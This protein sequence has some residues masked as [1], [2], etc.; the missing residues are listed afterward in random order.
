MYLDTQ[1]VSDKR[2]IYI[3][4]S[5]CQLLAIIAQTRPWRPDRPPPSD[6]RCT[7]SLRPL[8]QQTTGGP[9]YLMK[10]KNITKILLTVSL[11]INIYPICHWGEH[12]K[13]I[14]NLL[15]YYP[16]AN[17]MSCGSV[18]ICIWPVTESLL[19]QIPKWP[20][21]VVTSVLCN[22]YI[23]L[24]CFS[25]SF[26]NNNSD[27][28][29]IVCILYIPVCMY[30]LPDICELL[31]PIVSHMRREIHMNFISNKNYNESL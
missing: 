30:I 8:S 1:I 21:T 18:V 24:I 11:T 27:R 29:D 22:V 17:L 3:S 4:E 14:K 5:C 23:V 20:L 12:K 2:Y 7:L 16:G 15:S 9:C 26:C 13:W 19:A 28:I 31:Q 6:G 10:L 25:C